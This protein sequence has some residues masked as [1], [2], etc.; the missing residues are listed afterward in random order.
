[1]KPSN[2]QDDIQGLSY[3]KAFA[4]LEKIV[5]GLEANQKSLD[6]SIAMYERGQALAAHCAA[7]LDQAELR[8]RQ[9]G[10]EAPGTLESSEL[11]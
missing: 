5:A 10:E 6:E 7:L 9:L 8:V 1:V 2:Y 4:E 3:E 11:D